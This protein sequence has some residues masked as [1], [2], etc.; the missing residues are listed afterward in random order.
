MYR[1]AARNMMVKLGY[2][3]ERLILA[4]DAREAS[5]LC[6]SHDFCIALIDYNLGDGTNGLQLIDELKTK[7]LLPLDCVVVIVTGDSTP[8]VVRS[9]MDMGPDGYLIKPLNYETIKK[10]LPV[11]CK[12]KHAYSDV[13]VHIQANKHQQAIDMIE[14]DWSKDRDIVAYGQLLKAKSLMEL[15]ELKKAYTVLLTLKGSSEQKQAALLLA[16][17]AQT[18]GNANQALSLL[19]IPAKDPLLFTA[20]CDIKASIEFQHQQ[21]TKASETLANALNA[22]PYNPIRQEKLAYV[23]MAR[24]HVE[25]SSELFAKLVK[26]SRHSYR[27]EVNLH[28]SRINMLLDAVLLQRNQ[29]SVFKK[30]IDSSLRALNSV[31]TSRQKEYL[32]PL[33]LSKYYAAIGQS[34]KSRRYLNQYSLLSPQPNVQDRSL[35]ER[36]V[37][38][39]ANHLLSNDKL[40]KQIIEPILLELKNDAYELKNMALIQYLTHWNKKASRIKEEMTRLERQ[41]KQLTIKKEYAHLCQLLVDNLEQPL[42]KIELVEQLLHTLVHTWPVGWNKHQVSSLV[43]DCKNQLEG[44]D[45]VLSPAYKELLGKIHGQLKVA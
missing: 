33:I 42:L 1:T 17:L 3:N 40:F 45:F 2:Q 24:L 13:F 4:S 21:Y 38:A 20:A 44:T 30:E 7:K 8:A 16:K 12:K 39:Q 19:G 5:S 25:K 34:N 43:E 11:F 15:G 23:E 22:A 41:V 28:V 37:F 26:M 32:T 31:A 35:V 9:F 6:S 18:C 10:R 36:I 29:A 14:E 27:N